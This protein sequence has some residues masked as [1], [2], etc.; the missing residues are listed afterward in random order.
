MVS[1]GAV[2]A[3]GIPVSVGDTARTDAPVP[4][5][6]PVPTTWADHEAVFVPVT[7]THVTYV[8]VLPGN[9]KSTFEPNVLIVKVAEPLLVMQN[10]CPSVSVVTSGNCTSCMEEPVKNCW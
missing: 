10:V 7:A 5:I 8:E 9:D 2:G 4:V 6:V 1:A 3:S